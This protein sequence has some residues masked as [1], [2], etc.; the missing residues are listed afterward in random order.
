MWVGNEGLTSITNWLDVGRSDVVMI[1]V[2]HGSEGIE[3][4]M[5]WTRF[6]MIRNK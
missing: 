2:G 6:Q 4:E 3:R 5:T 1:E